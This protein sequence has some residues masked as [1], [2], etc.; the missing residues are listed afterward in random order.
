MTANYYQTLINHFLSSSITVEEFE[1]TFL[2]S[3]K[4]EPASLDSKLFEILDKLFGAVD[5]YW[6]E[7]KPG[8]ETAFEIS[9]V[10]LRQE[11]AYALTQ[12]EQY[13]STDSG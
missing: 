9:E 4:A 3:F 12:I 8:S 2:T 11:A 1:K 7:C 5:S 10:A 13:L 6:H